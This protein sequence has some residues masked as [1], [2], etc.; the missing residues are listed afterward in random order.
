MQLSDLLEL[1]IAGNSLL[2]WLSAIGAALLVNLLIAVLKWV[3]INRLSAIAQ[4]T[5]TEIDDSL[6]S[7]I[8]ATH[9]GLLL[10]V[11]LLIGSRMLELPVRLDQLLKGAA[12]I[13]FFAQVG[14]WG[15][16][17]L[18]FWLARYRARTLQTDAA[19][20]TSLAALSFIG[21]VVLWA[22]VLLLTLD[23]LG[24]DVTAMVAGLGVGGIAV[25]LAVQNILGDLFA[26]LSI[27]TDKPFVIGDF[28]IVDDYMGTVEYVGLKTTRVR[29]LGG[30]QLVFSNSDLLKAR[31]RNYKRM[32]ERRVVFKFGVLYET[33]DRLLE[34]IPVTVR[35]IIER[36][37]NTRFDRTHFA[38][39]GESSLDYEVVYW[40]LDPDYNLF[41]DT[42]QAINLALLRQFRSEGIGFAYP[43]RTL[44]MSAPEPTAT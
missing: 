25:A 27:V 12:T 24:I 1:V 36:Q 5:T 10:F 17:V 31:L 34:S 11:T 22:L 30:E 23:N 8:R 35:Q 21:R 32:Q 14:F 9:Q 20:A 26:S 19:A 16:A 2:E 37:P 6:I 43:T 41:M 39:F 28:I 4:R 38:G 44:Y 18:N 33:D 7:V 13:A 3:A 42:Q 40:M 29:S 15:A